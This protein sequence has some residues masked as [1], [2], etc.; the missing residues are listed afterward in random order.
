MLLH[1]QVIGLVGEREA[2][3]RNALRTV[4]MLD[5][6]YWLS[7]GTWHLALSFVYA[8]VICVSGKFA[9]CLFT[10]LSEPCPGAMST[11]MHSAC[12]LDG[13]SYPSTPSGY[14]LQLDLFLKNNFGVVFMLLFMFSLSMT[15][16]AYIVS[17]FVKKSASAT[18]LGFAL[19][20]IGW[21]MQSV[22]LFFPYSPEEKCVL[23]PPK[24]GPH[25]ALLALQCQE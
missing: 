20:V 23:P 9:H 4:G 21:V 3:L 7:W 6:S 19:F 14:I 18:V 13:G 1:A 24:P 2:G 15:T 17:A 12:Y 11:C 25:P 22:V 16:F 5:S 8:L 10:D